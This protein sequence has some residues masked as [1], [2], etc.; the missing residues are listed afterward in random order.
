M[1]HLEWQVFGLKKLQK[2][3]KMAKKSIVSPTL[4]LS[5]EPGAWIFPQF[6]KK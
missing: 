3:K 1:T 4:K 5:F 2:L 6:L